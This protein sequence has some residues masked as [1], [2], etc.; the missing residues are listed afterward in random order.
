MSFFS[1]LDEGKYLTSILEKTQDLKKE[2]ESN[3]ASKRDILF[4]SQKYFKFLE[5]IQNSG[6]PVNQSLVEEAKVEL[7][8]E[9]WIK[10]FNDL[11]QAGKHGQ[12][13]QVSLSPN[14]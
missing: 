5:H 2:L 6:L 11:Q 8:K 13:S 1:Q 4:D 10:K 7:K 3:Q 14:K 9:R 12:V